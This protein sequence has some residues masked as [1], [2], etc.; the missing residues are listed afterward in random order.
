MSITPLQFR[1]LPALLL[2]ISTPTLAVPTCWSGNGHCYENITDDLITWQDAKIAAENLTFK[3]VRGHLATITS[4]AEQD[5][6]N[7]LTP[8]QDQEPPFG[9][10][11]GWIG[12]FQQTDGAPYEWVT[13]EAFIYTNWRVGEPRGDFANNYIDFNW[14]LLDWNDTANFDPA[15]DGFLVEYPIPEPSTY[16]MM[17]MGLAGLGFARRHKQLTKVT[18]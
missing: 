11:R 3:G 7:T 15:T 1:F 2:C 16:L 10:T 14:E 12:G 4:Q 6:I 18:E 9:G 5:F 17:A 8:P 13:G